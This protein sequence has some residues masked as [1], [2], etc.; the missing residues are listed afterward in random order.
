MSFQMIHF[1]FY[2]KS[3]KIFLKKSYNFGKKY[4][5]GLLCKPSNRRDKKTLYI[6]YLQFER[7]TKNI[8]CFTHFKTQINEK[9][10]A[11]RRVVSFSTTRH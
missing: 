6:L 4:I 8:V 2:R 11:G 9:L 7:K 10:H 3:D 5:V 1:N